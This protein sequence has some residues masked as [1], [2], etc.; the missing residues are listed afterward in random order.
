MSLKK[1][2]IPALCATAIIAAAISVWAEA[3]Q[4]L[5]QRA[6]DAL[7]L[8]SDTI[9]QAKTVRFQARSMVPIRT[10]QGVWINLYG[11]SQVIMQGPDKLFATTGGDLTA[12][13]FD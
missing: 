7:K 5:D 9:S 6:L 8:M 13:D 12:R 2:L 11:T 4:L 1:I 3:P 10:P